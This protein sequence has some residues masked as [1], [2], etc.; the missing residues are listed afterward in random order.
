MVIFHLLYF[1]EHMDKWRCRLGE[2][3]KYMQNIH[4]SMQS[5]VHYKEKE[6]LRSFKSSEHIIEKV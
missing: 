5:A 3:N 6:N 2:K 1:S 4:N